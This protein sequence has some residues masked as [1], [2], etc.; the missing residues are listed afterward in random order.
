MKVKSHEDDFQKPIHIKQ[1]PRRK[2]IV[3]RVAE[4]D[5]NNKKHYRGRPIDWARRAEKARLKEQEKLKKKLER[6]A[7]KREREEQRKQEKADFK[8]YVK[9]ANEQLKTLAKELGMDERDIKVALGSITGLKLTEKGKISVNSARK[10]RT[11][12]KQAINSA[13][14]SK[15]NLI[16]LYEKSGYGEFK[17]FSDLK[18]DI[19][20]LKEVIDD[21]TLSTEDLVK[22][23]AESNWNEIKDAFEAFDEAVLKEDVQEARAQLMNIHQMLDDLDDWASENGI[24]L[25]YSKHRQDLTSYY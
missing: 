24:D 20:D 18:Y 25:S 2:K 3:Q 8:E 14:D 13:L 23:E 16:K 21:G 9:G 15:E 10:N 12:M 17:R 11:M 4:E 22:I 7:R 19:K 1:P 6:E 5:D